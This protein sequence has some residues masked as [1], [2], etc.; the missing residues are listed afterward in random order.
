[1]CCE[2]GSITAPQVAMAF[3]TKIILRDNQGEKCRKDPSATGKK[4]SLLVWKKA[5]GKQEQHCLRLSLTHQSQHDAGPPE[6][7]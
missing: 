6:S 4:E 1:M 5:Y 3:C 7:G 2:V